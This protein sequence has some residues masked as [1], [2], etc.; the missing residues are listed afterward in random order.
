M[1]EEKEFQNVRS[2]FKTSWWKQ[3]KKKGKWKDEG[4]RKEIKVKDKNKSFK[5]KA[6]ISESENQRNDREVNWG[7]KML[8]HCFM[9]S[10][11][12]RLSCLHKIIYSF[13][14]SSYF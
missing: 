13:L 11:V 12:Q 7:C 3:Y 4:K 8:L 5:R 14:D 6:N 10:W 1:Q 2:E 9:M